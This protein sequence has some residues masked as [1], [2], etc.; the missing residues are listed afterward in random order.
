MENK[1]NLYQPVFSTVQGP[2]P[3]VIRAIISN[4]NSYI[5]GGVPQTSMT[6]EDYVLVS[7]LPRELQERIKVAIEAL[8]AGM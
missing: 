3:L 6:A 2:A 1:A 5:G 4:N 8:V 7:S